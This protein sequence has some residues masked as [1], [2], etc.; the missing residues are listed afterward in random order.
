MQ[1][2]LLSELPLFQRV[3]IELQSHCNRTCY[4]CCRESD[5]RG[6]RKFADGR[7]VQQAMPTDKVMALLDE[8]QALGFTGYITFHQLSEAFLDKRLMEVARAAK[9]RG[10]RPYVHTNGDVLRHNAPLCAEAAGV[11]DYIVVGLYDYTSPAEKEAEKE[12]WRAR[13]R[14]TQVMFSL[15]EKVYA[16]THSAANAPMSL[17]ERRSYANAPCA[18]PLKYLL[19]HYNGDVAYCCEDM[20]GELPKLNI[21]DTSIREAWYCSRHRQIAKSLLMGDRHKFDLCARCTMAPNRYAKDPMHE[22]QHF[23]R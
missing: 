11:F 5:T 1:A 20:Y 4:F 2:R 7:S 12:F 21:F 9:T 15:A 18:D 6:K 23:D 17:L 16:R 22:A 8:L 3:V 14:G 10:M 19:I 13:L